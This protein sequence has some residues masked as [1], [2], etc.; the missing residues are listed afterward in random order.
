MLKT[1]SVSSVNI[2]FIGLFLFFVIDE[3]FVCFISTCR[4]W[5][6]EKPKQHKAL[7]KPRSANGL[8]T[9]PTTC[10]YNRDGNLVACACQDGSIQMW[11]HRKAFV[12]G[13]WTGIYL[14]YSFNQNLNN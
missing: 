14:P 9:V 4:L 10:T 7:M 13:E 2:T 6:I 8:K 1:G 11:D 3:Y 5:E 12:S